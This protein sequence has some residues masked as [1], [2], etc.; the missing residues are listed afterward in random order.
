MYFND[1]GEPTLEVTTTRA[2]FAEDM[3]GI[4]GVEEMPEEPKESPREEL[5]RVFMEAERNII[6]AAIKHNSFMKESDI[7]EFMWRNAYSR[8]REARF[9]IEQIGEA[10]A[11]KEEEGKGRPRQEAGKAPEEDSGPSQGASHREAGEANQG[12]AG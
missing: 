3:S 10:N 8:M 9:W 2:Y 5:V 11:S 4:I 7:N 6:A 1:Q 12:P